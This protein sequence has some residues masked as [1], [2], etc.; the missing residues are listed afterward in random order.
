MVPSR[1]SQVTS[2]RSQV[3]QAPGTQ[4]PPAAASAGARRL[5]NRGAAAA[6]ARAS[7]EGRQWGAA[8]AGDRDRGQ[9]AGQGLAEVSGQ[10]GGIE[11][12]RE[13]ESGRHEQRAARPSAGLGAALGLRGHVQTLPQP[14]PCPCHKDPVR[15]MGGA[16]GRPQSRS[17]RGT[18][19][20][21][22]AWLQQAGRWCGP[23]GRT[24]LESRWVCAHT[25]PSLTTQTDMGLH[26]TVQ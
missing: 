14:Q 5:S 7:A 12:Q 10:E 3:P 16:Q 4:P 26:T 21:S 17:L 1:R 18:G 13:G 22:T 25:S 19:E 2:H 11:E 9:E 20:Y 24:R 15:P 8:R 6:P 23:K